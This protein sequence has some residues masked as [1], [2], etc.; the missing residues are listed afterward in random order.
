[1]KKKG[2]TLIELLVVIAIIGLLATIA[3]VALNNARISSRD[4]KRLGD[5]KQVQTAMELYFNANSEYP[6]DGDT[7]CQGVLLETLATTCDGVNDELLLTY[8]PGLATL[9]DPLTGDSV[10]K[11]T[12]KGGLTANCDY[13]FTDLGGAVDYEVYFYVEKDAV[14]GGALGKTLGPGG[15]E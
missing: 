8:L 9:G 14:T 11:C 5:M 6:N 12:G 3:A 4:T 15:I 10:T 7:G 13:A 2:F 1:M